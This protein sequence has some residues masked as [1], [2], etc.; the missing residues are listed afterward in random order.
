MIAVE[1]YHNGV[2]RTT[3]GAEG[4]DLIMAILRW[5]RDEDG[6]E[7]E[8]DIWGQRGLVEFVWKELP[9]KRGDEIILRLVEVGDADVSPPEKMG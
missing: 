1:L 2:K 7:A 3:A 8:I 4:V 5:R 9:L 6:E